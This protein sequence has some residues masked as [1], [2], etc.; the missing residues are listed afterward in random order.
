MVS[1]VKRHRLATPIEC[2]SRL[3]K[4]Y[5]HYDMASSIIL[6]V[7][8]L[9]EHRAH[10]CRRR[11]SGGTWTRA[12]WNTQ[13]YRHLPALCSYRPSSRPNGVDWTLVRRASTMAESPQH[14]TRELTREM[15]LAVLN[16]FSTLLP[17]KFNNMPVRLVVH[18]GA[19][20]LLHPDLDRLA[21]QTPLFLLSPRVGH[22]FR[23]CL[24]HH[25]ASR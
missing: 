17:N 25:N 7:S 15:L 14:N 19:C 1:L 22:S 9:A 18:G 24:N 21:S 4:H 11:S 8:C 20:M 23:Y 16:H 6:F 10:D 13:P 12:T 2:G 3:E 5:I